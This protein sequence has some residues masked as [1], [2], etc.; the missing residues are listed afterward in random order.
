MCYDENCVCKMEGHDTDALL[1][2]QVNQHC[3]SCPLDGYCGD[4]G[5][6]YDY[7]I[8]MDERFADIRCVDYVKAAEHVLD[9]MEIN[10]V[11]DLCD[12]CNEAEETCDECDCFEIYNDDRA[13]AVADCVH[14]ILS[15]ARVERNQTG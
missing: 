9:N 12:A 5:V 10:V 15:K 1:V 6:Q 14:E 13:R 3:G 4:A 2:G 8:C 7:C 11:L